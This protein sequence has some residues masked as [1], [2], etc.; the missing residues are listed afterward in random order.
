MRF[1]LS[2][3]AL[4]TLATLAACHGGHSAD[5]PGNRDDHAPFHAIS[6]DETVHF[7][8]TEPFWSGEVTRDRLTYATPENQQGQAVT[9]SRFAGR[10][11][12]SFSGEL[13]GKPLTL[14]VTPAACSDGMSDQKYPFAVT[15]RL[16]ED[17]RQGCG[18]TQRQPRTGPA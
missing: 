7:T 12:L 2:F 16:G 6:A 8:G 18:W 4:P 10:G 15:L 14:A 17:V 5:V 9:V 1:R 13:G 11:G 3:L